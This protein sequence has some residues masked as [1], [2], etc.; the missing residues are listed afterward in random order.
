MRKQYLTACKFFLLLGMEAW[1]KKEIQCV[2][3]NLIT[4]KL[5]ESDRIF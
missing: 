1:N 5:E 4:V 2:I 3:E